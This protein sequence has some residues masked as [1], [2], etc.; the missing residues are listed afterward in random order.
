AKDIC[1]IWAQPFIFR[2]WRISADLEVFFRVS[3]RGAPFRHRQLGS[4]ILFE[5]SIALMCGCSGARMKGEFWHKSSMF[6][7]RLSNE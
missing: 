2:D 3:L 5:S 6:W 1:F 4:R 7:Q